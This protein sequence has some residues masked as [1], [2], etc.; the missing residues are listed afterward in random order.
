MLLAIGGKGMMIVA[1]DYFTKWFED[2]PMTTTTQTDI[3][4]FIWKNIIY[5]S[6]SHTPLSPTMVNS[7]WAKTW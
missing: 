7:L 2:E 3:D 4:R 1:T 5:R 6:V